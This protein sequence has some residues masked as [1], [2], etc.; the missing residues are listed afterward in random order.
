MPRRFSSETRKWIYNYLVLRDGEKCAICDYVPTTRNTLDIDH[1]DNNKRNNAQSNLRLACR[2]CNV[3]KE[4]KRRRGRP[5]DQRE[6]ERE[7][8]NT[9]IFKLA[10]PYSSGSPEMQA[11]ACYEIPYRVW[12]LSYITDHDFIGKPDAI[13]AG[14]EYVGCNPT[15]ARKYLDKLT[16]LLGPLAETKDATGQ[17]VIS[18]KEGT[19][20]EN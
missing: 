14:A 18:L 4:N 16:S 11:N 3:A 9:R 15:T 10:V 8:P 12:L 5:S 17:T 20:N 19:D 1:A 2:G 6:R 7:N 13:N